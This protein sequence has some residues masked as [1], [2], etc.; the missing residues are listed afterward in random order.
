MTA[1]RVT[2]PNPN[3]SSAP[4]ATSAAN[5]RRTDDGRVNPS[6]RSYSRRRARIRRSCA[7]STTAPG[8]RCVLRR[9]SS[10]CEDGDRSRSTS[11]T[12]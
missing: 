5:P 9:L 8:W 2:R 12:V 6:A 7:S 10:E 11:P 3:T 1:S 4:S